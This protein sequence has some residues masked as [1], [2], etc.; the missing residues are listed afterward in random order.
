MCMCM[1][2]QCM[3]VCVCYVVAAWMSVFVSCVY[4]YVEFVCCVGGWM[5]GFV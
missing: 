5:G 4:F 3:S 1:C 2:N